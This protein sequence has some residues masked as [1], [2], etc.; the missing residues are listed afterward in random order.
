MRSVRITADIGPESWRRIGAGA[1]VPDNL[2]A[3]NGQHC[4][5]APRKWT[6][7]INREELFVAIDAVALQRGLIGFFDTAKI[8]HRSAANVGEEHYIRQRRSVCGTFRH[9]KRAIDLRSV[10]RDFGALCEIADTQ[11]KPCENVVKV[12]SPRRDHFRE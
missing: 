3:A 12:Q 6:A 10:P 11:A 9:E 1:A 2:L 5:N 8:L 7:R 4:G